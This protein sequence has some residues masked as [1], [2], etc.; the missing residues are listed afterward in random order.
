MNDEET[1]DVIGD[2]VESALSAY[3]D[4]ELSAE[5]RVEVEARLA[6]DPQLASV[7]AEVR[8]TREALRTM[9][10]QDPPE[11]F[12]DGL[13]ESVRARD[14][15]VDEHA[16]SAVVVDM[17]SRRR[18]RWVRYVAGGAVAAALT[19]AFALPSGDDATP[20]LEEFGNAH[21]AEA[22]LTDPIGRVAP[23]A[24]PVSFGP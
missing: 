21:L 3:L 16:G 18:P 8:E 12:L 10:W 24:A 6:S 13:V 7:L 15:E 4:D 17:E 11:G 19:V 1:P 5:E 23:M 14:S 9:P 22:A 2:D 20:T